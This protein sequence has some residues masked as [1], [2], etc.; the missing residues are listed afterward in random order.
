[1][2]RRKLTDEENKILR[3][4]QEEYGFQNTEQDVFF[5]DKDDAVIFVK[6]SD[7]TM[8]IMIVLTNLVLFRKEGII[9]SDEELRSKWLH[10]R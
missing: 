3:M 10:P 4:I 6:A 8:P 9:A 7:G 2:T 5:S 1:M